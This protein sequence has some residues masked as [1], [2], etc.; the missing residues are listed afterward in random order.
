VAANAGNVIA[1]VAARGGSKGISGKNL[2][3]FCG[4]P[5]LAWSLEQAATSAAVDSVWVSTDDDEI[6]AAAEAS[7]SRPIRRPPELAADDSSSEAA[8]QHALDAVEAEAGSVALVV[9]LQATSPLREP[10]DIDRAVADFGSQSCDSLFTGARL[11]DFLIWEQRD[12]ALKSLNYDWRSRGRRQDRRPQFVENGSIYVFTP[13]LLRT[14]SNRLGGRIG[15]SVMDLWKSFEIDDPEDV[16]T[17]AALMR[18]YL[19]K[20][21]NG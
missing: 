21:S 13:E 9:A 18:H 1:L 6:A 19:L 20:E 14:T 16:E 17:C 12:G 5:L 11:D 10:A 2:I 15:V 8:W 4:K 7:G 3:D